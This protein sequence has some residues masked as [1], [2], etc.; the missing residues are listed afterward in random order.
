MPTARIT[1]KGQITI[2]KQVRERLGVEPGDALEFRFEDDRLTVHPVH[3][4]RVSDFRGL[5]PI[6]QA[7]DFSE[8]RDQ[9][10]VARAAAHRGLRRTR[11][12]R[13]SSMPTSCC[14]SSR[15][16]RAS[17]L[18]ESPRSSKPPNGSASRS[19]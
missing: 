3:R 7:R 1:S 15:T 18:T 14:A 16:S 2:P 8:E 13:R 12:V 9:A 6:S 17:W 11:C 4:R 19:S 5:F 10:W